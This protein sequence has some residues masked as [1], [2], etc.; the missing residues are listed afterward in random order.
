MKAFI[1]LLTGSTDP[2]NGKNHEIYDNRVELSPN[3]P[4]ASVMA[5]LLVDGVM[6]TV[7]RTAKAKFTRK[8]GSAEFEKAASDEYEYKI[9]GIKFNLTDFNTWID[10]NICDHDLLQFCISGEFFTVLADDDKNKAR[11]IIE[12]L[13]GSVN[14]AELTNDYSLISEE[15]SKYKV[16]EIKDKY[17]DLIKPVDKR[18][19]EIPPLITDKLNMIANMEA[20]ENIEAIKEQIEKKNKEIAEIDAQLGNTS[21]SLSPIIEKRKAAVTEIE[22]L[23]LE[24]EKKRNEYQLNNEKRKNEIRAEIEAIRNRNEEKCKLYTDSEKKREEAKK[25]FETVNGQINV[26][27]GNIESKQKKIDE[28]KSSEFDENNCICPLCN[29]P[30]HGTLLEDVR[31]EFYDTRRNQIEFIVLDGKKEKERL[32]GLE[33]EEKELQDIISANVEK[34]ILEPFEHLEKELNKYRITFEE[35]EEYKS[36]KNRASE[37]E[38]PEVENDAR[39]ELNDRKNEIQ[40]E[41]NELNVQFGT[42]QFTK[43]KISDLKN[44]IKKLDKEMHDKGVE[45]ASYEK[46]IQLIKDYEEE[47]A[48]VLAKKVNRELDGCS[49]E[50]FEIQKNG[51]QSPSC[52]IRSGN[53]VKYSVLNN[54]ARLITCI[55]IQK[56]FCRIMGVQLPIFCDECSIYDSMH[57]PKGA[58]QYVYMYCTDDKELKVKEIK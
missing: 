18:I 23:N 56:M 49:I 21:E 14:D 58:G 10:N 54:S 35:T 51:E 3:T 53:G 33:K 55:S 29:Q 36:L 27:K 48:S 57:L 4:V 31:K 30:I 34:P 5:E 26:V 32:E 22:R 24:I 2:L 46:T 13:I 28:L 25:R 9:D 47:K 45:I 19:K 7:E 17:K 41:I 52:T 1:W 43:Q 50:M 12:K 8:K 40:S 15:L 38:I 11:A 39:S 20:S 44:E 6:T 37:I 16:K 42:A